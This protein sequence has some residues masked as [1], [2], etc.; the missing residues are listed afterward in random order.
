MYDYT[1]EDSLFY[2]GLSYVEEI[3][4]SQKYIDKGVDYQR[5]LLDFRD[6]KIEEKL[7]NDTIGFNVNINSASE[8]DLIK[9]PG[10]GKKTASEIIN[11]R[12]KNGKFENINDL[13]KVKGIGKSKFDK[14]KSRIIVK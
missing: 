5:E 2:N 11:Y 14:I 1:R 13:L 7:S 12:N 9:L 6:E 4:T 3:D 10:I 8:S